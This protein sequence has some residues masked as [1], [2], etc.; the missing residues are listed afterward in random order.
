[1]AAMAIA[2]QEGSELDYTPAGAVAAGDVIVQGNLVGVAPAAIVANTLG[3]IQVEGIYDFAKSVAVG[4]G[5]VVGSNFYWDNT[6][7]NATNV[8]NG[9]TLIGQSVGGPAGKNGTL[10]ADTSVRILL[11]R[12]PAPNSGSEVVTI[13]MQLLGLVNA[14]VWK[15]LI[16]YAFTVISVAFRT[17]KVATTAA[18][19]ATLAAQISGV[20]C[21]G[22]VIALTSANQAATGVATAGTAITALN[23]GAANG[24]LEFAVSAVTPFVEGDGWIEAVIQRN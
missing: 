11:M 12:V 21:T 3:V 13:P 23:T 16:P 20:A 6:A 8:A 15:R 7:K 24:T 5:Q 1:M 22:G 2:V 14:A 18:K 4:S 10:D 17:G 9:N 19:L